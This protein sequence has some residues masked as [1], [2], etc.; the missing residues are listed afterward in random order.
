MNPPSFPRRSAA[1]AIPC[2]PFTGRPA[3]AAMAV[4]LAAC[5]DPQPPFACDT[6]P[7]QTLHV[8]EGKT[9]NV[10]F[11]DPEMGEITLTAESSDLGIVTAN[12]RAGAVALR[13]V[14]PG[15]AT[16][17]VTAT[18]PDLLTGTT[19]FDV[20]VP[21]RAPEVLQRI[22]P[23]RLVPDGWVRSD[24]TRYFNEP[25]GQEL[26]YTAVSSDDSIASPSIN[27][28]I[29]TVR[30][31]SAGAATITVTATDPGGLA[32]SQDFT[33]TV[34]EP[35]RLLR[36]DFETQESLDD[37]LF[38]DAR[39]QIVD[40][41]LRM[42]TNKQDTQ[43]WART[44]LAA[45]DWKVTAVMGN[46]TKDSWAQLLMFTTD[47]RYP[48]YMLQIGPDTTGT[49]DDVTGESETNY[50]LLVWDANVEWWTAPPNTYG[51][52]D[53]VKG[54]GELMTVTF[55]AQ[56]GDFIATVDGEQLFRVS[57]APYPGEVAILTLGVWPLQGTVG[58]VGVFDWVEVFGLRP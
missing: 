14:S 3:L 34:V 41:K 31:G 11:E 26:T 51:M 54:E 9:V 27:S 58:K 21:D 57:L 17:T 23:A 38:T 15:D 25:D 56:S 12:V 37:W 33:V 22:P 39:R 5:G 48:G 29:L 50:R 6:I 1:A 16:V 24:L 28:I 44:P 49:W 2:P 46:D 8:A 42:T 45:T 35:I 55:A 30:A 20:L 40:G 19:R 13:G 43:A 4:W 47:S 7:Q 52:S 53:A 36:D 32:A 10:C 18:D